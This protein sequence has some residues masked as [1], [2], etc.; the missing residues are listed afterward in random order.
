MSKYFFDTYATIALMHK[1][2]AYAPYA[3]TRRN[4][5]IFNVAELA[6]IL[7]RKN[8]PHTKKIISSAEKNVLPV[9]GEDLVRAAHLR[10][11]NKDLSMTDAIGYCMAQRLNMKF[12]TG[13]EAFKKLSNVEFVKATE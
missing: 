2:N 4:N 3:D 11:Q 10:K 8:Q 7:T 1:S 9:I 5:S 13:D 12:L 6:W